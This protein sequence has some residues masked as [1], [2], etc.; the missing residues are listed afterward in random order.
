MIQRLQATFRWQSR[1]QRRAFKALLAAQGLTL[2]DWVQ[3]QIV[4]AL[5]REVAP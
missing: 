3:A 2:Q 5:A 4:A 1:E